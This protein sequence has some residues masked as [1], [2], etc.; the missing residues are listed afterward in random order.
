M[1]GKT[2]VEFDVRVKRGFA[3]LLA[4]CSSHRLAK[5]VAFLHEDVIGTIIDH[6]EGRNSF[7]SKRHQPM[8]NGS[9]MTVNTD[10]SAPHFPG[11][12]DTDHLNLFVD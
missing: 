6:L 10:N 3:E 12:W 7:D 8:P 1:G 2:L 11:K 9:L 4:T 5:I